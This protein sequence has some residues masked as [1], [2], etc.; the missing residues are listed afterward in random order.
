[1][2]I[3]VNCPQCQ[4][5]LRVPDTQ[6]GKKVRCPNCQG[7]FQIPGG[8][9]EAAAGEP[10]HVKLPDGQ[11]YGPISKS[12]LDTWVAEGR[13]DAECQLLRA[14]DAQWQWADTVFPALA[15]GAAAAASPAQPQNPFAVDTGGGT[16]A[17]G[18]VASYPS[19]GQVRR[20]DKDQATAYL[21]SALP[22]IVYIHG[23]DKFYL[24][25]TGLG[26]AKLL[27]FGGC[28]IWTIIDNVI[29]G[30]GAGRDV[31]GRILNRDRSN[32][33][34]RSQM[35]AYVLSWLLGW[36]G[37]DRFYLGFI[38]LGIVKLLTFGGCGVWYIVDLIIV[39]VGSMRDAEGKTLR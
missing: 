25:Q 15:A 21:L 18:G 13:L 16:H 23:L 27:T 17:G 6:A 14:G 35:T 29:Y 7:V 34:T 38:G 28:G 2:P 20:S 30:G 32:P 26:I 4:K 33:G 39:G 3:D 37:A 36:C 24:G 5:K 22:A 1:M 9:A 10:W 12:E 8:S 19:G 31:Q 11:Q